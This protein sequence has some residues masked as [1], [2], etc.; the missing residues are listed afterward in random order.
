[1]ETVNPTQI[2]FRPLAIEDL[3]LLH[4]WLNETPSVV[5]FYAHGEPIPYEKVC[6]KYLPRVKG[7]DPTTSYMIMYADTPIGYIQAYL[8]RDYSDLARAQGLDEESAGL[9]LFIGHADYLGRGLG[10]H[11]LRS[12]LQ[13]IIFANPVVASCVILVEVRNTAALRAYAKAGF[14]Q[15]RMLPD[16]PD[17][18]GPVY[19]LRVGRAELQTAHP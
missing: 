3:P 1:M 8:W 17:E 7:E 19:L 10:P 18:P 6:K 14:R 15:L 5:E 12:F 2:S 11:V 16:L 4:R 13:S 9:D